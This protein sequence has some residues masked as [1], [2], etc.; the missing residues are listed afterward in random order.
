[1]GS[2]QIHGVLDSQDPFRAG[3]LHIH[4]ESLEQTHTRG[5]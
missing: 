1:M 3:S 4:Q 2:Q 5:R